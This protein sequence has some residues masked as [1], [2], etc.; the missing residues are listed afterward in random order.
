[1]MTAALTFLVV[2]GAFWYAW[3]TSQLWKTTKLASEFAAAQSLLAEYDGLHDAIEALD[4]WYAME[5]SGDSK[6][7][8]GVLLNPRAF[9][10][11][12]A[13]DVIH[14]RRRVSRFFVKIRRSTCDQRDLH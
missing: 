3:L 11:C 1:M 2:A 5:G 4:S 8:F 13:R 14:A 7:A 12:T 10:D 6:Q 9:K